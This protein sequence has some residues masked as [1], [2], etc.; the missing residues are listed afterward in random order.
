M[1]IYVYFLCSFEKKCVQN[2][3]NTTFF[4]QNERIV[5]QTNPQ[6]TNLRTVS[7]ETAVCRPYTQLATFISS[8]RVHYGSASSL[9]G[10]SFT[11][12]ATRE[13]TLQ[14]ATTQAGIK[15][16]LHKIQNRAIQT[17]KTIHLIGRIM[18]YDI[19]DNF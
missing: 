17:T 6:I 1:R 18:F 12:A 14:I 15:F 7:G 11:Y 16:Y 19:K 4:S 13:A 10:I 3:K 5:A 2:V 8:G 9:W